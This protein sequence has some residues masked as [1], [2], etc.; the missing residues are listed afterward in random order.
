MGC[1]RTL[2]I[3]FCSL[4]CIT[5]AG[6]E[7]LSSTGI[8]ADP[9]IM[10][11]EGLPT[12]ERYTGQILVQSFIV[13][14]YIVGRLARRAT[15]DAVDKM[16]EALREVARREVLAREA[17]D[18]IRRALNIGGAGRYSSATFGKYKLVEVIGHGGMGEV[19]R[20]THD[21]TSAPVAVK[22]I[23]NHLLQD[24]ELLGRFLREAKLSSTANSPHIV[25]VLETGQG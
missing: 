19:Y 9:G 12:I 17:R 2:A 13:A 15:V 16:Q 25:N 11:A 3:V 24:G 14:A 20:A 6:I 4:A 1:S 8:M 22:V 23:H 7:V 21:E 18:K 5:Q 10:T